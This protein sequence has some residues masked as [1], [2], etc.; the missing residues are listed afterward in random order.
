MVKEAVPHQVL[1]AKLA[2]ALS[3]AEELEPFLREFQ[4]DE[5]MVPF[6]SAAPKSILPSP[7]SRISKKEVLNGAYQADE[8]R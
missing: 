1:L 3:I 2:S 7:L 8:D 5:P 6:L 4:T